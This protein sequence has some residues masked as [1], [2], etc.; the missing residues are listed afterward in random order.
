MERQALLSTV[1][2]TIAAEKGRLFVAQ[3]LAQDPEQRRVA[4]ERMGVAYCK[5][6]WPEAYQA[7]RFFRNFLDKI[8]FR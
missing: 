6:R 7:K 8:A 4:E 2:D 3:T 5:L 1:D